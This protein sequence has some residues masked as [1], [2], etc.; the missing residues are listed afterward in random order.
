MTDQWAE[1]TW[2]PFGRTDPYYGVCTDERFR[3]GRL[4]E[5]ARREFFKSGEEHIAWVTAEIR[6]QVAPDFAPS[7]ILDFGCGVGRLVLPLARMATAVVGVDISTDMLAEAARN[8][9][10]AGLTNVSFVRGNDSL[11]EVTGKF[12]FVHSFIVMQ[13]IPPARGERIAQRLVGKLAPGGVAALHFTY[14][15]KAPMTRKVVHELRKLVPGANAVVN[16]AQGRPLRDPFIPMYNYRLDRMVQTF[17]RSADG[18]ISTLLTDH[19][20]HLGAMLLFR[21]A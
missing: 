16:L 13:H 6:R 21:V 12:D 8:A 14:G 19:G 5:E 2:R 15:R 3:A 4:D 7:R 11:D 18:E 20:G 10:D 9:A 1:R 17:R